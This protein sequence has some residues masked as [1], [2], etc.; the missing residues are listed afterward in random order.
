[1]GIRV[2]RQAFLYLVLL[3]GFTFGHVVFADDVIHTNHHAI[4]IAAF[5]RS[6]LED[7]TPKGWQPLIFPSIENKTAYFLSRENSN[8]VVKAVSN[9]SASGFFRKVNLD[10]KSYPLLNWNWKVDNILDK[11]DVNT[12]EGDDYPARIYISFY[13]DPARLKGMEKVKYNLY[14][15]LNDKE[16]PLAVINYIWDNK[17]PVGTITDNAYSN[18]VKMI[19]VQSGAKNTKRWIAEQRNLY[20]D[21]IKAFG[22]MPGNITGVAIMTD[23]D[24]TQESAVAYYGD[25]V[26]KKIN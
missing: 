1:M 7:L 9:A 17:T 18:R 4:N 8:T 23:T 21:Y 15:M 2:S 6:S 3:T 26:L 14:T 20:Q 11:A 10:P 24:N 22:E 19:T 13:Y 5:S 16:P 12:K 25:I